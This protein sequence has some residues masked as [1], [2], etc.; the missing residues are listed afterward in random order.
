VQGS[1]RSAPYLAD[2]YAQTK[3]IDGDHVLSVQELED[4]AD[5]PKSAIW[6]RKLQRI[7]RLI[8]KSV[9]D[10][11]NLTIAWPLL[12]DSYDYLHNAISNKVTTTYIFLHSNIDALNTKADRPIDKWDQDRAHAMLTEG[13][14][15]Q[16]F[17]NLTIDT[18]A[19]SPSETIHEIKRRLTDNL[20]SE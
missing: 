1:R 12:Q 7:A 10:Q 3:F 15:D 11:Q 20:L 16:P 2:E 14:A 4:I 18:T 8:N 9:D 17:C 5:L 13:Y 6:H 19:L